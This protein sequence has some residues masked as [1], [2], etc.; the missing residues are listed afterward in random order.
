MFNGANWAMGADVLVVWVL[1]VAAVISYIKEDQ[2]AATER[3]SKDFE[4]TL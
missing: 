3:S 4:K 2:S 1:G